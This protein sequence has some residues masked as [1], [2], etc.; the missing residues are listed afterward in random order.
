MQEPFKRST[1]PTRRNQLPPP[2]LPQDEY[3]A[4]NDTFRFWY[5]I[6]KAISVL[7]PVLFVVVGFGG[8]VWHIGSLTTQDA[9][10]L[11]NTGCLAT[12]ISGGAQMVK[13]VRR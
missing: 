8:L 10:S 11:L 5:N 3:K 1:A 12:G 2:R 7:L 6:E 13:K 4:D 9:W